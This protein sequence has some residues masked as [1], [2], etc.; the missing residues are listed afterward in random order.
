MISLAITAIV[1]GALGSVHCIGMCGPIALSLPVVSNNP[2]SRF[3]STLLYNAGRIITYAFLGSLFGI[4][5]MSFAFFGYQQWLSIIL[6]SLILVFLLLPKL[7]RSFQSKNIVL[8]IFEKT[9][10][11]MGNLF[12][13]KNYTSLFFIGLLN[14][15]LPCG[16]IYMAIAAAISTGSIIKSSLFMALFGFGT[17]P[18]MWSIAFFGNSITM[19]IRMKI[20]RLY[21]YM[22]ILMAVL[23]IIRG[24]GLHI[25]YI[26]PAMPLEQ[27]G[28]QSAIECYD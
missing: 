12:S 19:H 10:L 4:I 8:Q 16:L 6:G 20:K 9:R 14:G 13:R 11:A 3:I 18:V 5:G 26:S 24:L 21:P 22:M 28:I 25:P 15:L 1:L 2:L 23:L 17:L 7:T 27:P